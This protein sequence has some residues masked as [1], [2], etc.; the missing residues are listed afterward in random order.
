M[1]G[2]TKKVFRTRT[3][4]GFD[5]DDVL[6]YIEAAAA[7][8]REEAD[9][10]KKEVEAK[11][12]EKAELTA[13]NTS[14]SEKVE[15]LTLE[16]GQKDEE[17]AGLRNE[18]ENAKAIIAEYHS[19]VEQFDR[20][21][22]DISGIELAA[23]K[24]AKEI[25]AESQ[26]TL[27]RIKVEAEQIFQATKDRFSRFADNIGEQVAHAETTLDAAK[28][29]YKALLSGIAELKGNLYGMKASDTQRKAEISEEQEFPY[30]AD[31]SEEASE[32]ETSPDAEDGAADIRHLSLKDLMDRLKGK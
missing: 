7:K 10:L 17:I 14:L 11:E 8:T 2:E 12:K 18:L 4:G 23:R 15:T 9:A 22:S 25:E 21:K 27:E 1:G 28:S 26:I 24:R 13:N 29:G 5:K 32:Q 19:K 16:N 6:N 20:M 30:K 31:L 3:F